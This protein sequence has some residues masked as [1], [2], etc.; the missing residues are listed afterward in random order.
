MSKQFDELS[1][2]IINE[3][4]MSHIYQPV[5]LIELLNRQG[6]ATTK[7]IAKALLGHDVSQVEYY[8]HIT[9]NMVGKVLTQSRGIT[10]KDR[11]QYSLTSYD[12][13]S[14]V[15]ISEL[16]NLCHSKIEDFLEKRGDKVWNHRRKSSGYISG[17][18]RYEVLKRAKFRCEL[19]GISADQ[20]ALEVDHIVPRN[21]GGGD[22][23]SNL[24][25][26]CYSCNAMKR[27]R[28]D[29]DFR[30]IN[31]SYEHRESGCIFCEIPKER[32]IAANELAYAIL[33][34]FPV[35]EQHTL[36][37][38]KR[39]VSDYFRLHQPERNAMQQLL[40]ERREVIL[41]NDD[42]VTGFNVGTN[43]G[44]DAGQ[45][46]LHCHTHLIPRRKGDVEEPQGGVRGVIAEK[47]K[48]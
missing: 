25:A 2:F 13:L 46:V 8:E 43:I 14:D 29:T 42:S 34:A 9:K 27:D 38:S 15:E 17:T 6:S 36:I 10:S 23:Q 20:K 28:D 3:M 31:Q 26:L 35:T 48:Y 22:E 47:Q 37:I 21:S 33:D 40:E 19:C 39:H 30:Q 45:T 44:E 18:L 16:T 1:N 5:M 32:L 7:E 41:N 12:G 4:R 24:Q 11:N